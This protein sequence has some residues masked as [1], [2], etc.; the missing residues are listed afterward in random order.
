MM[1]KYGV[2][3]VLCM[4]TVLLNGCTYA[5]TEEKMAGTGFIEY[6]GYSSCIRLESEAPRPK[7]GAS[8]C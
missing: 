8:T 5:E 2:C 4:T 6:C 3:L 7:G 1:R